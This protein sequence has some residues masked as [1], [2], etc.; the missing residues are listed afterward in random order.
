MKKRRI[1][2]SAGRGRTEEKIRTRWRK[3]NIREQRR[4]TN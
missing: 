2:G 3:K 1:Q 4:K